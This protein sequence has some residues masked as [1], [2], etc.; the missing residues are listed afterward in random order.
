MAPDGGTTEFRILGSLQ[1]GVGTRLVRLSGLRQRQLLALLLLNP[2]RMVTVPYLVQAV[3]DGDPPST[4]KRQI[5]NCISALRHRLADVDAYRPV[6]SW[7]TG[8]ATAS[9]SPPSTSTPWRSIVR[10]RAPGRRPHRTR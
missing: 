5:Q 7:R 4:A 3:W 6:P 2:N 10:W 1:V 9:T 8:P